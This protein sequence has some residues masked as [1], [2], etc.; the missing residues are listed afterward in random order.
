MS[1]HSQGRLRCLLVGIAGSSDTYSLSLYCLKSYALTH[2]L[3]DKHWDIDV[4]QRGLISPQF[5]AAAIPALVDE[6]CRREPD[7]VGISCYVWNVATFGKVAKL[8]RERRPG[9]RFVWGGPEIAGDYISAGRFNDYAMDY[10]VVGEGEQTFVDLLEHMATASHPPLDSIDGLWHRPSG[11]AGRFTQNAKRAAVRSLADFPSPVLSGVI[12]ED[13]LRR[14]NLEANIETQRG[15][16][17]RCSYCVYHKDMQKIA[18][19]LA[20]RVAAEVA[21]LQARGVKRVRFNDANFT[22]DL[23]YSKSIISRLLAQKSQVGLMLEL[24]PG[25]ID[26]EFCELLATYKAAGPDNHVTIGVGVQTV[27]YEVLKR[28]R[29]GIR[30]ETFEKTFTL[31][32]QYNLFAKIDLIV[33]LPG[34]APA[35]IEATMEYMLNRLR[36]SSSHLLCFHIMRE[37]PGTELIDI[38]RQFGM[39]FGTEDLGHELIESPILPRDELIRLLRMTAVIFRLTNQIGWA[40]HEFLSQK[41]DNDTSIREA[42]FAASDRLGSALAVVRLLV[43]A[44]MQHLARRNSRFV[45]ADFPM[46]EAWWWNNARYEISKDWLENT[47]TSMTVRDPA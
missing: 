37:L 2:E 32:Q 45:Q 8:V 43:D 12:D 34:E 19:G 31:L 9:V 46:A 1:G 16:S 11:S 25:F 13:V 36:R 38:G 30:M 42:F 28:M 3:L 33:G 10:C 27:N 17:L 39:Q 44:L 5:E 22:S 29:R 26:A 20:D 41:N 24:V 14:P 7:L 6:I 23:D 15:C 18:Y 21:A 47:L 4:I 40:D 35:S